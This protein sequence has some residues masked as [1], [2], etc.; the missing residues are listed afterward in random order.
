MIENKTQDRTTICSDR[1]NYMYTPKAFSYRLPAEWEKHERTWMAWP[2]NSETWPEVDIKE[3]KNTYIDVIATILKKEDVYILIGGKAEAEINFIFDELN[4][5]CPDLV[6][7]NAPFTLKYV[8]VPIDDVWIR[9]FGPT[10]L[11]S[12]NKIKT[13]YKDLVKEHPLAYIKWNFNAWGIKN[14]WYND[15]VS[16]N[17]IG[18]FTEH[19][20]NKFRFEP[21]I[22]MEASSF[23]VNGLGYGFSSLQTA[24]GRNRNGLP[25][26]DTESILK[27]YLNLDH[28]FWIDAG[29]NF[30][31]DKVTDGPV[32]N[33]IR[34][35]TPDTVLMMQ[36]INGMCDRYN[37]DFCEKLKKAKEN[38]KKKLKDKN[39]SLNIISVPIPEYMFLERVSASYLN[40]YICNSSVLVPDYGSCDDNNYMKSILS[41]LYPD[42]EIVFIDCRNL[43]KGKG[44]LHCITLPE[45]SFVSCEG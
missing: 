30:P 11:T 6:G 2:I 37:S 41:N 23:E 3:I 25:L 4:K 36:D 19:L 20:K 43:I 45:Y 10:F 15:D 5:K 35:A 1:I 13:R 16:F 12:T 38:L 32:D 8:S 18:L 33:L 28:L 34:F 24:L 7:D 21:G 40:F 42:R 22:I 17:L 29:L 31:F 26:K 39:I 9:N 44:G 27:E 14:L